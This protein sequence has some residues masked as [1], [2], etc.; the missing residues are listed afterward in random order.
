MK[1]RVHIMLKNG[2]LDPQGEAVRHA[3]GTLGFDGVNG[4]RQGKVI[5]L[6]LAEGTTEAS[7]KDMCEKLLANTVIESYTIELT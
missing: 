7:V 1:A 6:D 3:L 4:V 2:V 5:E